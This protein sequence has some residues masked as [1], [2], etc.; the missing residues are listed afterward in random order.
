M[1]FLLLDVTLVSVVAFEK[2]I[3]ST[4]GSECVFLP[5]VATAMYIFDPLKF[6]R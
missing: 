2:S 1:L 4:G 3:L 6:S 5:K